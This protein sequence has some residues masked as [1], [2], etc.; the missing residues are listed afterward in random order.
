MLHSSPRVLANVI[1]RVGGC[2]H[3][4]TTAVPH[5]LSPELCGVATELIYVHVSPVVAAAFAIYLACTR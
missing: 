5:L 3:D 4:G 1:I 2:K